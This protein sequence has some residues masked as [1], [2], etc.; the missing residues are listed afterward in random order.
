MQFNDLRKVTKT[1]TQSNL[2]SV[3]TRPLCRK[4]FGS[5]LSPA[6]KVTGSP[7]DSKNSA[8]YEQPALPP[9]EPHD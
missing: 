4:G 9:E 5:F 2:I 7:I 3:T 1:A 8:C 6:T